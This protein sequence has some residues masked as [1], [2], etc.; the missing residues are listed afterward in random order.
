MYKELIEKFFDGRKY[1]HKLSE[2][3]YQTV[4]QHTWEWANKHFKKP[5]WC[6]ESDPIHPFGCWSLI[7]D[8]RK[9]ISEKYCTGCDSFRGMSKG[10]GSD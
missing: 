4:I 8:N 2:T 1:W 6:R 7:G 9:N 5:D 3:E 10:G